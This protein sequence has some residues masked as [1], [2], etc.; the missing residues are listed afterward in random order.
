MLRIAICDD[1]VYLVANIEEMLC[2]YLK[3]NL[4][5][6]IN[7]DLKNLDDEIE[8][9][10][11]QIKRNLIAIKPNRKN[12]RNKTRTANKHRINHRSSF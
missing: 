3:K 7:S 8:K 11:N 12:P 4:I 1:D 6:L 2:Q 9:L 10:Y 5:E